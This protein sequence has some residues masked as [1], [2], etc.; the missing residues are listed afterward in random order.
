MPN[1]WKIQSRY[2]LLDDLE[3]NKF[4]LVNNANIH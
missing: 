2:I 1:N 4:K 3:K